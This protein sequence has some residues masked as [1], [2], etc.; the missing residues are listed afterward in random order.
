MASLS[1]M[2]SKRGGER[3]RGGLLEKN[4]TGSLHEWLYNK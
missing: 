3:R 4:D 2:G 1:I